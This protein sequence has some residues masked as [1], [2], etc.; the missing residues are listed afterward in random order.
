MRIKAFIPALNSLS[1]KLKDSIYLRPDVPDTPAVPGALN[2]QTREATRGTNCRRN[3]VIVPSRRERSAVLDIS[4]SPN[5]SVQCYKIKQ[6]VHVKLFSSL[7]YAA[8]VTWKENQA[9]TFLFLI[10]S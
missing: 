9:V 6:H 5:P 8:P 3:E 4:T 10:V 2:S 1:V 7:V